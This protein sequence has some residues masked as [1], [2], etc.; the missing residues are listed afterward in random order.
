MSRKR[1]RERMKE[2]AVKLLVPAAVAALLLSA[3][4]GASPAAAQQP[5]SLAADSVFIQTAGSVGLLQVKLG[6]LAEKKASSSAVVDFGKR[7]VSD[8]SKTNQDLATAAKQ[9]A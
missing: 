7:M 4:A 2:M 5:V 3:A 6:N 9:A 8:Y 1:H